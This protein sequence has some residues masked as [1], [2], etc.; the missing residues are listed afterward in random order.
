MRGL[1][2]GDFLVVANSDGPQARC[3]SNTF[4][5]PPQIAI[6]GLAYSGR[7]DDSLCGTSF[8]APRVAWLLAAR[9]VLS[10]KFPSANAP[11]QLDLW[12]SGKRNLILSLQHPAGGFF[13]R[14]SFSVERLLGLGGS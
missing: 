11:E 8:S 3:P 4:D 2:P 1:D 10:G 6:I 7:L 12:I 5:D 14:Y 9:D 13:E